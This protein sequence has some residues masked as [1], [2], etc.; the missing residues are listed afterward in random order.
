M[1]QFSRVTGALMAIAA[2][3]TLAVGCGGSDAA[4]S[5]LTV[6]TSTLPA[7]T[8]PAPTTTTTS[9]TP[10][11]TTTLPKGRTTTAPA[12][13]TPRGASTPKSR[14]LQPGAPQPKKKKPGNVIEF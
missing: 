7:T 8:S 13:T 14:E 5:R 3:G 12:Q 6:P 9:T 1:V 4:D 11:R 10:S 2:T